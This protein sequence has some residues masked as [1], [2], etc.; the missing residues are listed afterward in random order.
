[1]NKKFDIP[2]NE[3]EG[4]VAKKGSK[5]VLG[6]RKIK[7]GPQA[8]LFGSKVSLKKRNNPVEDAQVWIR[9]PVEDEWF[10]LK[11]KANGRLLAVDEEQIAVVSGNYKK[12]INSE[13]EDPPTLLFNF[14][15]HDTT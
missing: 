5:N 12:E 4:N 11:N 8:G 6:I 13:Y 1:M 10:M 7:K 3:A 2:L 14:W 9:T 15:G